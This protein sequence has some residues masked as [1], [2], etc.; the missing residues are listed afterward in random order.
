MIYM[1][2]F[3]KKTTNSQDLEHLIERHEILKL[4]SL[5]VNIERKFISGMVTS[6]IYLIQYNIACFT[7]YLQVRLTN[8][9]FTCINKQNV[10][11]QVHMELL[12]RSTYLFLIS[13]IDR[14]YV[15]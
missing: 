10:L 1:M 3:K 12:L 4:N 11:R 2:K 15:I 7:Y 8:D 5:S 6:Q 13:L 9:T 14:M